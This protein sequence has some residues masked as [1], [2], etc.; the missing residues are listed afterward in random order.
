MFFTL[1]V[2]DCKSHFDYEVLNVIVSICFCFMGLSAFKE[3]GASCG[4]TENNCLDWESC[5]DGSGLGC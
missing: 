3:M 2:S 4:V 5:Q 1:V